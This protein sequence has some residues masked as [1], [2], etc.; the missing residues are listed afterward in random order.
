MK[1]KKVTLIVLLLSL[2]MVAMPF[3]IS[4]VKAGT[5]VPASTHLISTTYTSYVTNTLPSGVVQIHATF[6]NKRTLTI[7]STT[8]NLYSVG[9]FD[10]T[11][12]PTTGVMILHFSAV[13]YVGSLTTT[14]SNGFSGNQEI[15][16][17][18]PPNPIAPWQTVHLGFQGFGSFAGD[19][20]KL[21][22]EGLP[23]G[24]PNPSGYCLI[25]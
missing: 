5:W 15:K 6:T 21:D 17:Y 10:G 9:S 19:T 16:I 7:D 23:A 22:Y 20:L 11:K 18:T 1:K 24:A 2:L 4:T 13:W 25:P 14:T 12:N 3:M 8:Y